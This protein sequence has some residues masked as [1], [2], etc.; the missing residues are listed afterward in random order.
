MAEDLSS[1]VEPIFEIVYANKQ[2][3]ILSVNE[4]RQTILNSIPINEQTFIEFNPVIDLG[5]YEANLLSH[6][7]SKQS[8]TIEILDFPKGFLHEVLDFGFQN[9]S[10]FIRRINLNDNQS[11]IILIKDPVQFQ[12][13]KLSRVFP[14]Y[15]SSEG[16]E[17]AIQ[18]SL[19][20]NDTSKKEYFELVFNDKTFETLR[21]LNII[22][23]GGGTVGYAI[24]NTLSRIGVQNFN[25]F[26][27]PS[28]TIELPNSQRLPNIGVLDVGSLKWKTMISNILDN[29]PFANI[30]FLGAFDPDKNALAIEELMK[31]L[32][33]EKPTLVF[34]A[35]DN[36]LLRIAAHKVF[37]N[38]IRIS[39]TDEGPNGL[40][41][42]LPPGE[43]FVIPDLSKGFPKAIV[44]MLGGTSFVARNF[45][46]PTV[47]AFFALPKAFG[48]LPQST[49]SA[50][51]AMIVPLIISLVQGKPIKRM[52]FLNASNRV[53]GAG[54]NTPLVEKTIKDIIE[55]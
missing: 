45:D 38:Y 34:M 28:E 14:I 9:S 39:P 51:E 19:N 29:N 42:V 6:E 5:G 25:F 53:V 17:R 10:T 23:V 54:T 1:Q 26:E 21:K 18:N 8:C 46:L 48:A 7:K 22:L 50:V 47:E 44:E 32:N 24:A 33:K 13:E 30:Q 43:P 35:L 41:Q 55:S 31:G 3:P 2:H 36:F 52:S 40:I 16:R 27:I 20:V 15:G 12:G 4:F 49:P 37:Q 11:R